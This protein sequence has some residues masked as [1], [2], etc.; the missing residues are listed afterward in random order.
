[1]I[2]IH[3]FK[4]FVPVNSETLIL[5]SFPGKE[6]TQNPKN[7]DWFYYAKRN[8]FWKIIEIVF[9]KQLNTVEE[10]QKLFTLHHI[11]ITDIL[12]SCERKENKNSDSN[13][14]NKTY[15]N[16]A[17]E[18]ILKENPISRILF[19]SKGVYHEFSS[20]FEEPLNV[21]LITLPSPSPI[22][23]RKSLHEKAIEYSKYLKKA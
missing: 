1:M 6:S 16:G 21:E 5:G 4:P 8:Q 2:E 3:P 13:L 15:N 12:L 10:K 7:E 18:S 19:T 11:A 22:Y 9:N 20:H 14:I 17:I 23:R